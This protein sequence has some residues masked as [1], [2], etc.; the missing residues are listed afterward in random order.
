MENG[1]YKAPLIVG[2]VYIILYPLWRW[3]LYSSTNRRVVCIVYTDIYIFTNYVTMHS[4]VCSKCKMFFLYKCFLFEILVIIL[5]SLFKKQMFSFWKILV[6]IL[7]SCLRNIFFS[8]QAYKQSI[9]LR[10]DKTSP[11]LYITDNFLMYLGD[12]KTID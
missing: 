4:I 6:I 8:S 12:R 1:L 5:F 11:T 2:V 10:I 3:L 7:F 9:N